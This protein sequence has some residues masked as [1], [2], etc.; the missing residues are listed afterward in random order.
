MLEMTRSLSFRSPIFNLKIRQTSKV[1]VIDM[2]LSIASVNTCDLPNT[3]DFL[4]EYYPSVLRT[5]CFNE[6]NLPFAI[7]VKATE[8]GHLF[9]HILIDNLCSLK[10]KSGAKKAS[11]SG[12][13]SWNWKENP[14]GFFQIWI[15][16][17]KS[18]LELLI[19]GLKETIYLT[20][21]LI[22]PQTNTLRATIQSP[23][24]NILA[25]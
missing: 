1:T 16:I 23:A 6:Q 24:E 12:T 15:D 20:H 4:S 22:E 18:D 9:E 19:A 13:T 5:K 8:I 10:I 17:G 14:R 2:Q 7:E 11:F 21:K 25:I 3:F